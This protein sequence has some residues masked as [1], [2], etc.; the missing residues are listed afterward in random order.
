[1]VITNSRIVQ[2]DEKT[3]RRKSVKMAISVVIRKISPMLPRTTN[4]S[5]AK[6]INTEA[7]RR[8]VRTTVAATS[9]MSIASMGVTQ[10][11]IPELRLI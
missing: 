3:R 5:S 10:D 2:V 8:V 6:I 11:A 7:V 4:P 9:H 1:M